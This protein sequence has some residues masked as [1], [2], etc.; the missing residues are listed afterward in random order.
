M[1]TTKMDYGTADVVI[2]MTLENL[3]SSLTAARASAVISNLTDLFLSV[4]VTVTIRLLATGN[5]NDQRVYVYAYGTTGGTTY[6]EGITGSEAAVTLANPSQ[7]RQ[8]GSILTTSGAGP[9]T[10]E[11]LNVA[12]AFGDVV[13]S[14][15][16]IVIRNYTGSAFTATAG[17]HVVT[18]QGFR[19]QHV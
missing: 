16:G 3:A 13:P 4:L 1:S 11:P 2:P 19:T 17:H 14:K 18:Y 12:A 6:P 7:L 9:F 8:I 15:W 10:S 5:G